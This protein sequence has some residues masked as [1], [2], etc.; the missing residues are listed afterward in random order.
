MIWGCMPLHL[1]CTT[2]HGTYKY[3]QIFSQF[4]FCNFTVHTNSVTP[5]HLNTLLIHHTIV[6]YC[7]L[8]QP[9]FHFSFVWIERCMLMFGSLV[10]SMPSSNCERQNSCQC[11]YNLYEYSMSVYI[12]IY[13]YS[14]FDILWGR[15]E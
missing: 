9:P 10:T 3:K 8:F 2:I 7:A 11:R 5:V 14:V 1:L 4:C 6:G 12:Y 15:S 13:I